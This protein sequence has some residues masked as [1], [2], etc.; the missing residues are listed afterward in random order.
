MELCLR[1]GA[2]FPGAN[3]GHQIQKRHAFVVKTIIA[4]ERSSFKVYR[5]HTV[6]QFHLIN[7]AH[8]GPRRRRVVQVMI[9]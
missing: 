2:A 8:V 9:E 3:E 6:Q 1:A 7:I 4:E 5:I